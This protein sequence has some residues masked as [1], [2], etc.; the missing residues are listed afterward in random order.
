MHEI[1]E[2]KKILTLF[3]GWVS[4]LVVCVVVI[5]SGWSLVSL[6]LLGSG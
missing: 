3:S 6:I 2:V 1:K 5:D 4:V